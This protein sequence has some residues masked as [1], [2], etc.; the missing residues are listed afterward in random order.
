MTDVI[1]KKLILTLVCDSVLD[2]HY[3]SRQGNY[4]DGYS[5]DEGGS[6]RQSGS[7]G[8]PRYADRS[9]HGNRSYQR[10]DAMRRNN[11]GKTG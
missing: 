11:M 10:G 8:R 7:G 5:D 4:D 9:S 3:G 1:T 2:S 6:S